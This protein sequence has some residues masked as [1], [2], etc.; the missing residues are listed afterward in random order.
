LAYFKEVEKHAFTLSNCWLK[1]EDFDKWKASFLLWFKNGKRTAE[2]ND[3][4]TP[5]EG[6][7]YAK[8]PRGHKASKTD[9]R[10]EASAIALGNTLKS[11]FADKEEASAKRDEQRRRDKEKHMQSFADIQRRTLEI[12]QRKLDLAEVK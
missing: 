9:L 8:R 6:R 2:D 11:V 1:L 7:A 4:D 5:S 10:R 12:Q 3:Q